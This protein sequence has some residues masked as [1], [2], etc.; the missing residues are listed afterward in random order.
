MNQI[1][2]SLTDSSFASR[3]GSCIA[4]AA[5]TKRKSLFCRHGKRRRGAAVV[6]F[7]I[8]CPVFFLLV[9]GMIE[10]GR[11]VMVQQILTN[12]SREGA[13][14]GVLDGATTAEVRTAVT[15]Y[16]ASASI[17]GSTVAVSPD[18]PSTAGYGAPV[19][20]TVTIPFRQVSWLPSPMFV[21]NYTM[22]ASSVMRRES[23]Q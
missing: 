22:R 9:F 13:R 3:A 21:G 6:E 23:V 20:V 8:V 2:S 16:L 14:M 10:Y 19:T 11:L 15:N 12:A 7:A 17:S 1:S 4:T 5:A 18:P